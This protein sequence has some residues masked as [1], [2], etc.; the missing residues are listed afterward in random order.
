MKRTIRI[1]SLVII[2]ALVVF[3]TNACGSYRAAETNLKPVAK[4]KLSETELKIKKTRLLTESDPND[5]DAHLQLAE[6]LL[7]RVRE[8]GDYSLN[9]EARVSIANALRLDSDNLNAQVMKIQIDLSEHEFQAALELTQKLRK[10]Y[11][12]FEPLMAAEVDSK[13]ELG[14][15]EE[16]V[17]AAQEYVDF[18]PNSNS[19]VRVAHLRSLHGD[20]D[21]A[22]EARLMALRSADP[23]NKEEIAWHY[24][25][26]G[27]EY[28]NSGR[29]EKADSFYAKALLAFPDYHWALAGKGR[30]LAAQ[31]DY[32]AAETIYR[33]LIKV[34]EDGDRV[35]FLADLLEKQGKVKEAK[36][37][38]DAYIQKQ[39]KSGGDIHRIALYWA[40]RDSNLAASLKIASEDRTE[41]GDL[42]SSDY[43]AWNLY[44][45]GKFKE[46][47]KY[48]EEAMRL[49]TKNALFYYHAGM[50]E[51]ALGNKSKAI[52]FLEQS[53]QI[54]P[55]FD[56]IQSEI[57]R[58]KLTELKSAG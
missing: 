30:V 7:K 55:H 26:L 8:T 37:V 6:A 39:L 3:L 45:N 46:A 24:S 14:R 53:R 33:N 48:M 19:Y 56:L 40:D 58:K 22:L 44:K 4:K 25:Q 23:T 35:F 42:L 1:V 2:S 18:K 51:S 27:T 9:E 20:V 38:A 28:F 50:I 57:L 32:K 41:N 11:P 29:I 36:Q 49:K 52:K 54:N 17:N 43:L 12:N 16:A 31:R 21:G 15:F 34:A 47:K 10:K 13:T 5:V